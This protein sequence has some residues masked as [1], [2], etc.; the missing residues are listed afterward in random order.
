MYIFQVIIL[1]AV[2]CILGCSSGESK[3]K[4]LFET[5]Q[6]EEKQNNFEHASKLYAEIIQ[7]FP[8]T[9]VS[10]DATK[11]LLALKSHKP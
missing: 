1:I 7:K 11:R 8:D 2:C 5:A 4:E 9:E 6:F 3:A 10:K